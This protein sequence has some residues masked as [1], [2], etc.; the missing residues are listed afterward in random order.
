LFPHRIIESQHPFPV[1]L[2]DKDLRSPYPAHVKSA[3]ES[4]TDQPGG[5]IIMLLEAE[6]S[7]PDTRALHQDTEE[8]FAGPACIELPGPG[9]EP[10]AQT[11]NLSGSY[12]FGQDCWLEVQMLNS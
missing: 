8:R 11:V 9:N 10:P 6:D 7:K 12:T 5:Y 2:P 1:I 4:R 3:K